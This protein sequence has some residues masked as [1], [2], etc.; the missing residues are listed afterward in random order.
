MADDF[1]IVTLV[2]GDAGDAHVLIRRRKLAHPA[3]KR[4]TPQGQKRGG[5]GHGKRVVRLRAKASRTGLLKKEG[6]NEL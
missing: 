1:P 2:D 4:L 3:I 5:K 6:G